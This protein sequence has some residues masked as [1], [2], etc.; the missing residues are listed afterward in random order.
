MGHIQVN[1][2]PHGRGV[3]MGEMGIVVGDRRTEG[4]Y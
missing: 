1:I 2:G 4:H 3:F